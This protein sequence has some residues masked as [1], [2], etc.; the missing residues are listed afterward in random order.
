[1]PEGPSI[2]HEGRACDSLPDLTA[3]RVVPTIAEHSVSLQEHM[4][5]YMFAAQFVRGHVVLDAGCGTGYG[6][7][8][9]ARRG[10]TRVFGVD[11]A[12]EAIEYSTIHYQNDKTVFSVMDCANLGFPDETFDVVVSLEV[13]EHMGDAERYLSEMRRVLKAD[14][15]FILSTPNKTVHSPNSDSPLTPFHFEEYT[16]AGLEEKLSVY[17]PVVALFGQRDIG[18]ISIWR[19]PSDVLT[20]VEV[21]PPSAFEAMRG[22]P[23]GSSTWEH[24]KDWKPIDDTIAT[25]QVKPHYILAVCASCDSPRPTT[26]DHVYLFLPSSPLEELLRDREE[27]I[28]WLEEGIQYRDGRIESLE[29]ALDRI[30][31]SLPYRVYQ[32]AKRLL[33]VS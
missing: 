21:V 31:R 12:A 17:F 23:C 3:E 32:V 8:Y 11:I 14:G 9:L 20:R 27:W 7:A 6:A 19:L 5:R 10:A 30:H 4:A 29:E 1:M 15:V 16:I 2:L 24:I 33:R 18:G 13:I 26:Q 22:I 28:Q 25:S